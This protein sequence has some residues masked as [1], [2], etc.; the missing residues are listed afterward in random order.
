ML[1]KIEHFGLNVISSDHAKL[2]IYGVK[3]A[4]ILLIE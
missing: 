1:I 2:V 3:Y 4:H